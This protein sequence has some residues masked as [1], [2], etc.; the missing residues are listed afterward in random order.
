MPITQ[1]EEQQGKVVFVNR[2]PDDKEWSAHVDVLNDWT[3]PDRYLRDIIQYARSGP[4][5]P[6]DMH[7]DL[8]KQVMSQHTETA[9]LQG[10]IQFINDFITEWYSNGKYTK[11]PQDDDMGNGLLEHLANLGSQKNN[12]SSKEEE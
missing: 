1:P 3:T 4:S 6:A 5:Y 9:V 11:V 2:E 7:V 12:T 8:I 10:K